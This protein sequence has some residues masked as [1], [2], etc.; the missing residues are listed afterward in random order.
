M[1]TAAHC[2]VP[3]PNRGVASTDEIIRQRATSYNLKH[4]P[5]A[6]KKDFAQYG[7]MIS[8]EEYSLPVIL[9]NRTFARARRDRNGSCAARMFELRR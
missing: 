9:H 1:N 5:A 7:N 4:P 6:D 2:P 3:K 8:I